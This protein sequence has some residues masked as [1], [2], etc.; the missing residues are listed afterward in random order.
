M[1]IIIFA[2]L[3]LLGGLAHALML[4]KKWEDLKKVTAFRR[5][6]IGAI[7]G[8][9][10]YFIWSE[11]NFPNAVMAWVAGYWGTTFLEE[12]AERFKPVFLRILRRSRND[13]C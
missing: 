9:L 2:L 8:F 5:V 12:F 4:A 7:V 10:Y 13:P 6:V 11:W 1:T 3:G